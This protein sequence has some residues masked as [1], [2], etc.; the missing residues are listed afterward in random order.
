[1]LTFRDLREAHTSA[2]ALCAHVVGLL[3]KAFVLVYIDKT[4]MI[5]FVYMMHCT[6]N[7]NA[8]KLELLPKALS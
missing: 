4:P 1:M 7:F 2:L 5:S 8:H 6:V 3:P